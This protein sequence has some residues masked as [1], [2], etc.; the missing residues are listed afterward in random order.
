MVGFRTF[1]TFGHPAA[2][3]AAKST[4]QTTPDPLTAIAGS[5]SAAA[6]AQASGSPSTGYPADFGNVRPAPADVNP[7]I[8]PVQVTQTPIRTFLGDIAI[9]ANVTQ[10]IDIHTLMGSYCI[11]FV[12]IPNS[13]PV[14]VSIN[15]G[16]FRT[17][18]TAMV[19]DES[20]IDNLVI[21]TTTDGAIL[22]LNGA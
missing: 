18:P 15:G 20:Y 6:P 4:A 13:V 1:P 8:A 3:S 7:N 11:G 14:K 10:T 17:V 19:V 16:G 2:A 12:L 9:P 21:Q 5:G 22:D